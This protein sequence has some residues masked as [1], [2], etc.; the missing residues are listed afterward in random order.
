MQPDH[1]ANGFRRCAEV[2]VVRVNERSFQAG[3]VDLV[4]QHDQLVARIEKLVE[5][6]L[7]QFKRIARLGF[8]LH[9]ASMPSPKLQ[10]L[11]RSSLTSLQS[12]PSIPS[13]ADCKNSDSE[14]FSGTTTYDAWNRLVYV[15]DK[16]TGDGLGSYGYD[17]LGR[18]IFKA[19]RREA[20]GLVYTPVEYYYYD[21]DR[22]VEIQR[23]TK[24]TEP[25]VGDFDADDCPAPAPPPPP[26]PPGGGESEKRIASGDRDQGSKNV[27][28]TSDVAD[29]APKKESRINY[30]SQ[31]STELRPLR[32]FVYGTDY[33]TE[34]VAQI[35]PHTIDG[36]TTA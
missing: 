12:I 6:S 29:D 14:S 21:G 35:T 4:G 27:V 32:R 3:P 26:P 20:E 36:T 31:A 13:V 23:S 10:G 16:A 18:R 9:R 25:T 19:I 17:V 7:E 28:L 11:G 5:V 30:A 22:V 24:D 15:A 8:G 34:V 2:R 1:Q 33:L